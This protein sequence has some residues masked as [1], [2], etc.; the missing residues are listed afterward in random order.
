MLRLGDVL[1]AGCLI[2]LA[3]ELG[4]WVHFMASGGT[5]AKQVQVI[6]PD[7]FKE[8]TKLQMVLNDW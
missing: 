6:H 7:M 4:K 1:P 5:T 8:I 3:E 2:A